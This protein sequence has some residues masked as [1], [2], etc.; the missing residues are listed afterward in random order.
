MLEL[1]NILIYIFIFWFSI[2][3]CYLV[4][5]LLMVKERIKA[6]G[7][8]III[9]QNR[10]SS[11]RKLLIF[12]IFDFTFVFLIFLLLFI[13]TKD[14]VF[15]IG[16]L[17]PLIILLRCLLLI[18]LSRNNGIYEKGIILG[19]FINFN[20]IRSYKTINNSEIELFLKNGRSI[21]ITVN[22]EYDKII[23]LFE[24]NI[25]QKD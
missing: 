3:I 10:I 12:L 18:F 8:K 9:L 6:L 20:R 25:I 7:E 17:F 15:I 24:H 5:S 4:F 19:M 21:N 23:N 22:E 1:R 16:C 11:K 13:L 2:R 14:I